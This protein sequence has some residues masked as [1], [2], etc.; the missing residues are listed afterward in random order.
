MFKKLLQPIKS[1][2]RPDR[3]LIIGLTL[4]IIAGLV[5]LFSA[6][7]VASYIRSGS[8]LYFLKHQVFGLILGI[9]CFYFLARI[10]YHHFRRYALHFLFASL[11]VLILVFIP[12]LGADYGKARNW[13]NIFG[14]SLQPAEFVKLFFLF[15]LAAWFDAKKDKLNDFYEG[16]GPL[17]LVFGVIAGLM[18]MQPDLGTLSIIFA[19]MVICYFVA[20]LAKKYVITLVVVALI[21]ILLLV[22]VKD[23]K[24]ERIDC[25]RNPEKNSGAECYQ[26]NQ[27]LIAIGSGGIFGRG[28][29]ESRQKFMY[30][31]EVWSDSVFAIVAEE[32]GF[33]FSVILLGLFFFLFYRGIMIAKR[34]PDLYGRILAVGIVS[35]IIV[36]TILNIGGA[37]NLIPMTG[38]PLP[39]ISSGGS[40]ILALL[41]AMGV[42]ANISKQTRN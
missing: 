26:L 42:L 41:A 20:G 6:S 37:I 23:N 3:G 4:I 9:P 29:G 1:Y 40:S 36:Q 28:L 11:A 16:L 38:V 10:D 19:I 12:G 33:I 27:S 18:L 31:P 39:F 30:L 5:L 35:W 14:F 7:A 2:H 25:Y 32:I 13:I 21:G 34:A 8:S 17:I 24:M 15:Y 22:N